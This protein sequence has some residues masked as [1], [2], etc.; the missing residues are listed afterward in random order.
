[1]K[2]QNR[3]PFF[4]YQVVP[5]ELDNS[6]FPAEYQLVFRYSN[7]MHHSVA[8]ITTD[9]FSERKFGKDY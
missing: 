7:D 4:F 9:R 8:N 5:K 1:M 6:V 2:S 3:Q